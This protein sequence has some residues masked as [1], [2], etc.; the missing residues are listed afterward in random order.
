MVLESSM[1][2]VKEEKQL[3]NVTQVQHIGPMAII[4]TAGYV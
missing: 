3:N 1:Q 4:I 2:A